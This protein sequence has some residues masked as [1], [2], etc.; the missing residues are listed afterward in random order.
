VK[1]PSFK[2]KS[3]FASNP[4]D[5]SLNFQNN[6]VS[7]LYCRAGKIAFFATYKYKN[8]ASVTVIISQK[9]SNMRIHIKDV[10]ETQKN[11]S[12]QQDNNNNTSSPDTKHSNDISSDTTA[13]SHHRRFFNF[14]H[15]RHH[16]QRNMLGGGAASD[17]DDI[18]WYNKQQQILRERME[19]LGLKEK[20]PIEGDGN[21]Q[22][23][24]I[25]DQLFDNPS[26]HP[27]LRELIVEW[28]RK[29]PDF[30]LK[31]GSC[32]RDFLET[33][34]YENWDL[35][36]DDMAHK[37]VWGDNLTLFAA[38]N[39]LDL[40]IVVISTVD[41]NAA[42]NPFGV[43]I[44]EPTENG[45]SDIDVA[46]AESIR[47]MVRREKPILLS[48]IHEFHYSSLQMLDSE[49]SPEARGESWVRQYT[50]SNFQPLDEQIL[51]EK[52]V[53][54]S[55]TMPS[56]PVP[57]AYRRRDVFRHPFSRLRSYLH[58]RHNDDGLIW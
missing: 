53:E 9:F 16:H 2:N 45:I 3:G 26:R 24:S 31:N 1:H 37:G 48:H 6:S 43:T 5:L 47:E 54:R 40:K 42:S 12:N 25:C 57:V 41:T 30:R 23:A 52:I 55:P 56:E 58:G 49:G 11:N 4:A 51:P 15:R 50:D 20:T 13:D 28:L 32:L 8:H 17:E 44:I 35:Y 14:F 19:L 46:S 22:F 29:N 33:D 27:Q 39:M 38:S 21:C 34:R 36:C 10:S 18:T 7:D